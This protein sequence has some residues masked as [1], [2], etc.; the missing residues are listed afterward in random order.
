MVGGAG[1][2]LSNPGFNDTEVTALA[3]SGSDLYVGGTF[4]MAGDVAATNIA[5]WD[6]IRIG[7][8]WS[9]GFNANAE[10]AGDIKQHTL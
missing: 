6:G 2:G 4:I 10:C 8:R 5:K 3:V 9:S 7:R 1:S